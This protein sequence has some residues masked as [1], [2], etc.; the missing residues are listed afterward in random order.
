MLLLTL[1]LVVFLCGVVV[2]VVAL[3]HFMLPVKPYRREK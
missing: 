1:S 2:G 3:D